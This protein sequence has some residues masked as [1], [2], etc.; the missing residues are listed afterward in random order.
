MVNKICHVRFSRAWDH[1]RDSS[2]TLLL[3]PGTAN[4]C[5][6]FFLRCQFQRLFVQC[7]RLASYEKVGT[8]VWLE[9]GYVLFVDQTEATHV[10]ANVHW[11]VHYHCKQSDRRIFTV[12]HTTENRSYLDYGDG[13]RR[14]QIS[15][16]RETVRCHILVFYSLIS[17][18][19][20]I[21]RIRQEILIHILLMLFIYYFK[22]V[23]HI[24]LYI[25][26]SYFNYIL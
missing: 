14:K 6:S 17:L 3:V 18:A 16:L 8:E 26:N 5:P 25:L 7:H 10:G 12:H 15:R 11:H 22:Y 23:L 4:V 13:V 1:G 19:F 21:E 24:C 2:C 9:V 20:I